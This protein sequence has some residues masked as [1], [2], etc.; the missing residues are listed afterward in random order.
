M[1]QRPPRKTTKKD[2]FYYVYG[3]LH[4]QDYRNHFAAD[5]TKM[6]PR[7]P[8]VEEVSVFKNIKTI[9]ETLAQLHLNYESVEPWS[10]LVINGSGNLRVEKM[11]FAK[12]GKCEDR[13]C[14]WLNPTLKVENIPLEAYSYVVN[15]KSPLEWLMERYAVTT[16]KD[17]GIVNDANAWGLEHGNAKY[18]LELLCRIVTVSMKTLE[19]VAKLPRLEF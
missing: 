6:L 13:S 10:K 9:G 7:I 16:D 17:S 1:V 14:I 2:I 15:G 19:C 18:I 12:D 3:L 4:S 5:L 8:L 11:R